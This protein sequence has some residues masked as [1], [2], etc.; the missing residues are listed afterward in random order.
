MT[1]ANTAN[2]SSPAGLPAAQPPRRRLPERGPPGPPAAAAGLLRR[3]GRA[4]RRAEL[5]R[6]GRRRAVGVQEG[7]PAAG[8]EHPARPAHALPL[9]EVEHLR[10]VRVAAGRTG[11]EAPLADEERNAPG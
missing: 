5:V 10:L 8:R 9:E 3:G 7:E 4:H 1:D 6:L 11:V 2:R